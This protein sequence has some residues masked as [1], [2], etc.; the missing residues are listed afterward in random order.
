M[1]VKSVTFN[2]IA[3]IKKMYV[4]AFAYNSA[5]KSTFVSDY[6]DKIRFKNEI[7]E[8]SVILLPILSAPHR[9]RMYKHVYTDTAL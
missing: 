5:R 6:L 4:W 3:Q 1:P 9:K 7:L 2:D 8:I